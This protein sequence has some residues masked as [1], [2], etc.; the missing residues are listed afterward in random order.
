MVGTFVGVTGVYHN[1]VTLIST[2][3]LVMVTLT[4]KFLL[5]LYLGNLKV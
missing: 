2:F 5:G 1:G 3:D 4:L